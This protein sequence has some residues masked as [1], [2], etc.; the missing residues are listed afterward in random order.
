MIR[1]LCSFALQNWHRLPLIGHLRFCTAKNHLDAL[2][3]FTVIT[4]FG[5]ATFWVTAFL[6]LA[7]AKNEDSTYPSLL[8]H[9]MDAGQL[10]IFSVGML[11]PILISVFDD[12]QDR[13]EQKFPG[14]LIHTSALVLLGFVASGLYAIQLGGRDDAAH[15]P[16]NTQFLFRSSVFIACFFLLIR[17]LTMVYRK[18][19]FDPT[20][21]MEK[22]AEDFAQ[23][24]ARRHGRQQ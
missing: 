15:T 16:L 7:F 9:T 3:D 8:K 18:S 21:Q 17:Y 10:F 12:P 13:P 14:R 1:R 6:L 22:P 4:A 19:S 2:K 5:T 11:G 24:F 20:E 23:K